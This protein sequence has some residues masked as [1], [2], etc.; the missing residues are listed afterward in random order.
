M[1]RELTKLPGLPFADERTHW[2]VAWSTE[3]AVNMGNLRRREGQSVVEQERA[4]ARKVTRD[5]K[6]RPVLLAHSKTGDKYPLLSMYRSRTIAE[7]AHRCPPGIAHANASEFVQGALLTA[8][9][10]P[11]YALP[12]RGVVDRLVY[13][14]QGR[15]DARLAIIGV[16]R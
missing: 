7:L 11:A 1:A 4:V 8:D 15:D 3:L 13:N 10:S 2:P 6:S 9:P 12:V 16:P 5:G 14:W